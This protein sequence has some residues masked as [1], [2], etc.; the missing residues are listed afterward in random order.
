MRRASLL[1]PASSGV[2][3]VQKTENC[4]SSSAESAGCHSHR[5]KSCELLV[6]GVSD[7]HPD[8]FHQSLAKPFDAVQ[9]LL[10]IFHAGSVTK[11]N[12]IIRAKR[13]S[14][15]SRNFFCFEQSCA[16]VARIK[17][18]F[19]NIREKIKRSLGVH[20]RN[21][22]NAVEFFPRISSTPV[23]L[24]QPALQMILPSG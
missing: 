23:E 5:P 11:A 18:G 17:T 13:N 12:A 3:P 22:G 14:W 7:C 8:L 21:P 16:K 9:A 2:I 20:T 1:L 10:D 19:S 6:V 4:A 15:H 24:G